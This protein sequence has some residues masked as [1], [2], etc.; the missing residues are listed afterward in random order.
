M[1]LALGASPQRACRASPF[2]R[3]GLAG[4][5]SARL[6]YRAMAGSSKPLARKHDHAHHQGAALAEGGAGG[7]RGAW[8]TVDVAARLG[9]SIGGCGLD[10]PA[11]AYDVTEQIVR[12][13]RGAGS[14]PT[15]ST[16]FSTCSS[17]PTS[18]SGSRAPM[19]IS[20]IRTPAAGTTACS[21]SAIA[22]AARR[23]S[24]TTAVT[25]QVRAAAPRAGFAPERPVIEVHGL[26]ADCVQRG[27]SSVTA[28][29]S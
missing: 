6:V 29:K 13:S 21:W 20:P 26:C 4:T 9:G 22:A 1:L 2:A 28:I 15:A 19:P 25:E 10:R 17:P 5:P 23:M 14:P 12:Q 24:T 16:G 11:S 3:H 7:T 27:H 8:R 18:R